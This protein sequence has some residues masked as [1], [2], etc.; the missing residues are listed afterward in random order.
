MRRLAALLAAVAP[1]AAAAEAVSFTL[2]L[3]PATE[4]RLAAMGERITVSAFYFG[5]PKP[6]ADVELDEMGQVWLG[7]EEVEVA[8]VDQT[9]TLTAILEGPAD[10]VV[11]PMV[12]VNVYTSRLAHENNLINCGIIEGPI[13]ELAV[14]EQRIECTLLGP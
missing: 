1:A 10:R 4:A 5:D 2:D 7:N 8:P 11:A 6:G 12:N 14:A 9:V 13:A 3:D